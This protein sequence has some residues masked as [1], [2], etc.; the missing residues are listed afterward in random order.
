MGEGAAAASVLSAQ[1]ETT[2]GSAV[3]NNSSSRMEVG[4][5]QVG[6]VGGSV[7]VGSTHM[8]VGGSQGSQQPVVQ[9]SKKRRVSI[10]YA[11]EEIAVAALNALSA[12]IF[13]KN[14]HKS[15]EAIML[16]QFAQS[17]QKRAQEE[18]EQR[19]HAVAAAAVVGS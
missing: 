6:A 14:S 3:S 9:H 15:E 16:S 4:Q 1:H 13:T 11:S 8:Q 17:H 2:T 7:S 5:E 12:G 19:Q 18:K 10:Q